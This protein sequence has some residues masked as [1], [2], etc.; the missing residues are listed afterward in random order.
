MKHKSNWNPTWNNKKSPQKTHSERNKN[1]HL[2]K[3]NKLNPQRNLNGN[4]LN[5][6]TWNA[7]A[8]LR[9]AINKARKDGQYLK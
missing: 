3:Q 4:Y 2:E 8:D 6:A 1:D 9:T 7:T 5:S